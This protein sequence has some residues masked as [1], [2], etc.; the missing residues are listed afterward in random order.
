M[1]ELNPSDMHSWI[2]EKIKI[3]K[4]DKQIVLSSR[5]FD[6]DLMRSGS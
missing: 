5:T 2:Q 3:D 1:R 6:T 4:D